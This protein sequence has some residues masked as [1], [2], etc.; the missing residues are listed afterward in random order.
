MRHSVQR[1]WLIL[2]VG[3]APSVARGIRFSCCLVV[4]PQGGR[5][6]LDDG[7]PAEDHVTQLLQEHA[8]V[9]SSYATRPATQLGLERFAHTLFHDPPPHVDVAAVLDELAGENGAQFPVR[10]RL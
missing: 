6:C 4:D 7:W 8:V 10:E 5:P 9:P 1:S 3:R 2:R